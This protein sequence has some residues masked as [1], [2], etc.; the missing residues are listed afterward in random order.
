L[1]ATVEILRA[2]AKNEGPRQRVVA[3][4]YADWGAGQLD[5]EIQ[6][7]VWLHGA[8]DESLVFDTYNDSKW[9]RAMRQLGV[10]V[11]MLSSE[12]GHA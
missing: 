8:A 5:A 2:I 3:L 12:A 6:A 9:E 11:S 4:G 7:N 10:D 1:T